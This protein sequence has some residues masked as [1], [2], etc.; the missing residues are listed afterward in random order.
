MRNVPNDPGRQGYVAYTLGQAITDNPHYVGTT[1]R[2]QWRTGWQ[3]ARDDADR[4][5][6]YRGGRF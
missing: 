4:R 3:E 5:K 2:D 1:E 6:Y